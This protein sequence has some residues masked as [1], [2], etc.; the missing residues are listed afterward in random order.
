MEAL[1]KPIVSSGSGS[2][3]QQTEKEIFKK[4][5]FHCILIIL[6]PISS[7]FLLKI[8]F[9][10]GYLQLESLQSNL[11]SAFAAVVVLHLAL[12]NFIYRAYFDT[13]TIPGFDKLDKED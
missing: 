2:S 11:Y 9:F 5:L 1:N 3:G 8:Y 12:G 7:F 4:V 10:D 6:C 13:E